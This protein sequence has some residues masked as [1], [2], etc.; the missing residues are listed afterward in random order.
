MLRVFKLLRSW[1]SLQRV[2][3]VLLSTLQSLF[4]L[5]L[6][7][8][9][10]LFI[11][12]LLGMQLFG[13]PPDYTELPRTNFNSIT[14]AMLSVFI[15]AVGEGWPDLWVQAHRLVG[16]WA[17]GFFVALVVSANFVLLNLVVAL[18]VGS[19]GN[20]AGEEAVAA[21]KAARAEEVRFVLP[22][23]KTFAGF[24]QQRSWGLSGDNGSG[25][26][27]DSAEGGGKAGGEES[28][29]RG[30]LA[31]RCAEV[32]EAEGGGRSLPGQPSWSWRAWVREMS[33]EDISLGLFGLDHPV[34]LRAS[35]L[36][37]FRSAS[38]PLLS[39]DSV[40]IMLIILSSAEL[41]FK[42]CHLQE[43]TRFAASLEYVDYSATAV[44]AVEM[45]AK[46]TSLGL[47][48]TPNAYL[49]SGWNQLDGFIVTASLLSDASP[50][51][52]T[53]RVLRVLRP[54]RLIARFEGMRIVVKL[55][56]KAL[57]GVLDVLMVFV[58]FLDV[59][60]ILG[61]QLFAGRFGT[62]VHYT[63]NSGVAK[64]SIGHTPSVEWLTTH[65]SCEAAG[66]LWQN[67]SFGSFDNVGTAA[68]LLFEMASLEGW[69]TVL[70]AGIDASADERGHHLE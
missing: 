56:I 26:G 4:Y 17:A 40:V 31:V 54:L 1:R 20:A 61:V 34:R 23:R 52:R 43:G 10:L 57:P 68:L 24:A 3:N 8:A 33:R 60:A 38:V 9:L 18:I 59:F 48:F 66:H 64:V 55:L 49:K 41:A 16:E 53:L 6:L 7:L 14:Y 35:A 44:F 39:F 36:V 63:E 37:S 25:E 22:K 46:V 70:F 2:L 28:A 21:D 12:A 11:F 19:F 30:L 5:M 50:V 67:P 32:E 15:V 65:A 42:S 62:C 51:F 27:G 69:P 47:L 45:L 58:L 13:T 29:E